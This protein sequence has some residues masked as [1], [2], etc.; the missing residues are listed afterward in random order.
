M[1]VDRRQQL[2]RLGAG[3]QLEHARLELGLGERLELLERAIGELRRRQ[4]DVTGERVRLVL[5]QHAGTPLQLA[6]R[7]ARELRDHRFDG[8]ERVVMERATPG[9]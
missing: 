4:S 8:V 2:E 9:R 6:C 1:P 5:E 7:V 3:E